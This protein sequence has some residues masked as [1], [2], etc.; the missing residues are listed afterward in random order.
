MAAVIGDAPKDKSMRE[1]AIPGRTPQKKAFLDVGPL[2]K[3]IEQLAEW[4]GVP[5]R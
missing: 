5:Y 4:H 2:R 1:K 3:R